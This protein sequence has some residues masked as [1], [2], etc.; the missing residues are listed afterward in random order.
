MNPIGKHIEDA[1]RN[2]LEL[3]EPPK[4]NP[5][6][7]VQ[8]KPFRQ[9]ASEWMVPIFLSVLIVGMFIGAAALLFL[10]NR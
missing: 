5:L 4:L 8:I 1:E 7:R 9:F 3:V 6:M 10:V 2:R